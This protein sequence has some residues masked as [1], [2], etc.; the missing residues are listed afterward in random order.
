GAIIACIPA[1]VF[2]IFFQKYIVTGL[3]SGSVKG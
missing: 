3:T 1:F 2:V